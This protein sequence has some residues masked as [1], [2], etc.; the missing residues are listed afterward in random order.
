MNSHEQMTLSVI[1]LNY[2]VRYFLEQCLL[3]V[4][5]AIR[6]IDAEIIVVDNASKDESCAMVKER[7]PDVTLVENKENVGFSKA[8]NQAVAIAKGEYV[9]ILNPD[10]ALQEHTFTHVLQFAKSHPNFGAIGIRYIDGTGHFLPE[11]KRNLPT[12][13]VSV[14]K[15]LGIT[16][17]KHD[18][19]ANHLKEEDTGT[20]AVLAGAF[21]L[22]KRSRYLELG[23]FDEDYF[24]YGEDIDLSYK[25]AKAGYDN[26]YLGDIAML[27]YKGESTTKDKVYLK[28]FYGAMQIF[29]NKHFQHNVFLGVMVKMGVFVSRVFGSVRL[30]K[31]AKSLAAKKECVCVS[32][33]KT[34]HRYFLD[35]YAT[36]KQ[37]SISNNNLKT[38]T[39]T[40]V[41]FDAN[42]VAY[43]KIIPAM[44][45]LKNNH[46][47][48]R[49]HPKHT[50]FTIGSDSSLDR[51]EVVKFKEE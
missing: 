40:Q 30:S 4:K 37:I 29:Y 10:T 22:I 28:R 6:D 21:M 49:I 34:F 33:D 18:Y 47:C 3:T 12:P 32:E 14:Y 50:A 41:I 25:L 51:G 1:I 45:T 42:T 46:N 8:N 7:F 19:Y 16:S 23:G 35:N 39:N 43:T 2:N 48:F 9:C 17:K 27:H 24:M 26:Y 20:V 13:K 36:V 15:I 5:D 31:K 44:E 11:S 38:L